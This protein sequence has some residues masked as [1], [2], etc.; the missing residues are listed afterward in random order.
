MK[1]QSLLLFLSLL[2]GLLLTPAHPV[3]AETELNFGIISTDASSALKQAWQ[4]FVDDLSRE[5]GYKVNAFFASDYAGIIEGMRF[6]K[7]QFAWMGNKAAI[8]AVDRAEAE[9]FAQIVFADGSLGYYSY[10]ITHADS[11]VKSLE[12]FLLNGKK[13]TFGN[14]DPNSTSGNLVPGFY[15]FAKNKIDPKGHFKTMTSANHGANLAA[16]MNKQ[17]D[18]ATNNSEEMEKLK[19]KSPEKAAQIRILWTSPMIPSD[20][21]VCRKDL[22]ADVKKKIKDFVIAYGTTEHGRSVMKGI[23]NYG[24]FRASSDAQLIPIRQLELFKAKVKVEGD[25]SLTEAERNAKIADL[26]KKLAELDT[27][28]AKSK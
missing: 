3:Q 2:A 19:A 21:I 22:P 11:P 20:P 25:T 15:V 18:V 13:Y 8:E 14:G 24:G 12:D 5:T 4:P 10:L 23:Y 9:V 17:V 16:V 6:N 7:V 26:D 27:M 1:R 28:S